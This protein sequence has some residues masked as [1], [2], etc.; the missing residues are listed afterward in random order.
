MLVIRVIERSTRHHV[1]RDVLGYHDNT[2][3]KLQMDAEHK[4]K[5]TQTHGR[6]KCRCSRAVLTLVDGDG[7]N[8]T[9]VEQK[10]V[11]SRVFSTTRIRVEAKS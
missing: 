5:E 11:S 10:D 6:W 7:W 2:V 9:G 3:R 4:H 8:S 1:L